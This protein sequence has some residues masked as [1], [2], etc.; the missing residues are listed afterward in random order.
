VLA[1]NKRL[2]DMLAHQNPNAHTLA[3]QK[4]I[5]RILEKR[6]A[7]LKETVKKVIA[8][9]A[10]SAASSNQKKPGTGGASNLYKYKGESY[11]L[12]TGSRG[13]TYILISNSTG[14]TVKKYVVT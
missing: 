2:G 8:A 6:E 4:R 13:G 3:S 10:R 14:H 1:A 7:A 9:R 5:S 11:T 12:R